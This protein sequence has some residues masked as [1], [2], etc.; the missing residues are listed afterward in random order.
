MYFNTTPTEEATPKDESKDTVTDD[1]KQVTEPAAAI[2]GNETEPKE[3]GK[4]EEKPLE[5]SEG[6]LGR[7]M[8]GVER[9]FGKLFTNKCLG[10]LASVLPKE[11]TVSSILLVYC[12]VIISILQCYY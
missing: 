10:L 12:S 3:E 7:P 6:Y 9:S 4:K 2:T 11:L 5:A 8:T 1:T